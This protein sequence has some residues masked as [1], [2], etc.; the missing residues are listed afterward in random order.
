[1]TGPDSS[2]GPEG[3]YRLVRRIGGGG[4]GEVWEADDT[5]LGRRVA[6]KVLAQELPTMPERPSGCPGGEGDRQTHPSQCDQGVRLR[7]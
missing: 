4:M 3:R 5:L 7:P 6:L 1:M 2:L